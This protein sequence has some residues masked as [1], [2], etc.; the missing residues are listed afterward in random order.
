MAG[1]TSW[2]R[3]VLDTIGVQNYV[4]LIPTPADQVYV[5]DVSAAQAGRIV[6][7]TVETDSGTLNATVLINGVAVTGL[8]A[9]AASATLATALATALNDVVAGD[10]ITLE[11]T[12]NAAGADF[13][14][15][16]GFQET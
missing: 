2:Q 15:A 16:I 8:S 12:G 10:Q 13:A 1:R 11:V 5:V 6:N 3:A 9:V 4:G 14:W 7:L